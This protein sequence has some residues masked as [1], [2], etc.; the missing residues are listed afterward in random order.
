MMLYVISYSGVVGC[1]LYFT[2][3]MTEIVIMKV[4]YIFKFSTVTSVNEYF[5][6]TF[7]ISFNVVVVAIHV[8][9]RLMLKEY[10][11]SAHPI[12]CLITSQDPLNKLNVRTNA[13]D[14]TAR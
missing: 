10:E 13:Q 12:F 11:T 4:L 1:T 6:K 9:M 8:V 3:T 7:L 14:T 2:L 5:V